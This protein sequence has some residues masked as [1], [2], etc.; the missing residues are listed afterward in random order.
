MLV[1]E[2]QQLKHPVPT[3]KTLERSEL[4]SKRGV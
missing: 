4:R 1:L 2:L 3:Q